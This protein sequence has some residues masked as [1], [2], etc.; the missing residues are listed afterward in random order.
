MLSS[1][2]HLLLPWEKQIMAWWCGRTVSCTPLPLCLLSWSN[3]MGGHDID[4]ISCWSSVDLW[5]TD[6]SWD[7]SWEQ[8]ASWVF[9]FLSCHGPGLG[10]LF[11]PGSHIK[12]F[13]LFLYSVRS[14]SS[15]AIQASL[16]VSVILGNWP[17]YI[18]NPL[19]CSLCPDSGIAHHFRW[20]SVHSIGFHGCDAC[21][22][23]VRNP[24]GD[25]RT[26]WLI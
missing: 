8:P 24:Y 23:I 16:T 15:L 3:N 2:H 19:A 26:S 1:W 18:L 11:I 12:A 21:L 9:L 17:R 10:I 20:V 14:H 13:Y 4:S 5:S 6:Q 7:H 25:C 22:V